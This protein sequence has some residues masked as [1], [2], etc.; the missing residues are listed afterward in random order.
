M[1]T[2]EVREWVM[3]KKAKGSATGVGTSSMLSQAGPVT[4]LSPAM[5]L[6]LVKFSAKW[7]WA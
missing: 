4:I 2:P 6:L 3:G 5:S 7:G 1:S